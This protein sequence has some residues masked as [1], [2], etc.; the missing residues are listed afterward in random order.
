[1]SDPARWKD[2][3]GGASRDAMELLRHARP[4]V[5][6]DAATRAKVAAAVVKTAAV[7]AAAGIFGAK[8]LL[9][10]GIASAVTVGAV[11]A[12]RAPSPSPP[13]AT[14]SSRGSTDRAALVAP[15]TPRDTAATETAAPALAV[16]LPPSIAPVV[17]APTTGTTPP[18]APNLI[19]RP[20]AEA[21]SSAPAQRGGHTL[22]AAPRTGG[23]VAPST[24]VIPAPATAPAIAPA[25]IAP[26][27]PVVAAAPAPAPSDLQDETMVLIPRTD[28]GPAAQLA[29][30]ERHAQAFPN[31][32]MAGDRECLAIFALRDLG[33]ADD[34]RRRSESLLRRYPSAPCA[35]QARRMLLPAP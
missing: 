7:P 26:A 25:P 35:S 17:A 21:P 30:A 2:L 15:A 12:Y 23:Y 16:A 18:S 8:W 19:V 27:G 6:L 14:T 24:S 32:Q 10:A 4:P 28:E 33:R 11:T 5:A 34:A 22:A 9:G 20:A 3:N 31:G 13:R 29:R 1:M